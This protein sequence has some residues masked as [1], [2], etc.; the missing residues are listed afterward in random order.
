MSP[1]N[2]LMP[3]IL[4]LVISV[5]LQAGFVALDCQEAPYRAALD[6]TRAYFNLDP[7]MMDHLYKGEGQAGQAIMVSSFIERSKADM[8]K[9]GLSPAMAK[10]YLYHVKTHTVHKNDQE[11]EVWLTAYRKTAINPVFFFTAKLFDLGKTQRVDETIKMVK[12]DGR[13]KVCG[14]VFDLA[15]DKS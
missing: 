7:A 5:L 12:E 13:W 14:P 4:A 6:F 11:A 3:F 2:K 1:I 10:S 15:V 8:A 9:R